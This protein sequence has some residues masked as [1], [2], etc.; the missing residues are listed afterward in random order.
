MGQAPV[1]VLATRDGALLVAHDGHVEAVN[2]ILRPTHASEQAVP[3]MKGT[4]HT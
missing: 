2:V 4:R 1:P 3:P